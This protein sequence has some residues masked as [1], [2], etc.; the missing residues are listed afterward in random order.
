[1][2]N[3]SDFYY[4]ADTNHELAYLEGLEVVGHHH[5]LLLQLHGLDLPGLGAL[6]YRSVSTFI[7]IN[8]YLF[9]FCIFFL[10][11]LQLLLHL[12]VDISYAYP[13]PGFLSLFIR[14][15]HFLIGA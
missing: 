14:K 11:L 13:H 12:V 5:Q 1:M 2:S 15:Y 8:M 7:K 10:H 3:M 6:L 4:Y 9:P